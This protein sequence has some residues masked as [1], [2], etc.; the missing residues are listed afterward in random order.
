MRHSLLGPWMIVNYDGNDENSK[1]LFIFNG[2]WSLFARSFVL[3]SN[4]FAR[5]GF[6][7]ALFDTEFVNIIFFLRA[8]HVSPILCASMNLSH[9]LQEG[10]NCFAL[11]QQRTIAVNR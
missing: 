1:N 3:L 4:L 10:E 9:D 5:S 6:S 2:I 7:I 11:K 8:F